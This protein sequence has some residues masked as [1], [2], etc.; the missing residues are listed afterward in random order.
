MN[1]EPKSSQRDK[2]SATWHLNRAAGQTDGTSCSSFS[3]E[4]SVTCE[5]CAHRTVPEKDVSSP[6]FNSS[7]SRANGIKHALKAFEGTIFQLLFSMPDYSVVQ[8][9]SPG[10][11]IN[12]ES[13]RRKRSF[14]SSMLGK[15]KMG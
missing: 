14:P 9:I 10:D 2:G 7:I 12:R 11:A 13:H 6:T 8:S 3:Q 5:N 4:T 1:A 15:Q